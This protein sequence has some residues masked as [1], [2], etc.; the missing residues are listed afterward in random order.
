MQQTVQMN[1]LSAV[2]GTNTHVQGATTVQVSSYTNYNLA[3]VM[4]QAVVD[5]VN[6]SGKVTVVGKG[7][8]TVVLQG[9][10]DE[11]ATIVQSSCTVVQVVAHTSNA[12]VLKQTSIAIDIQITTY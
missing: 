8:A 1:V 6:R 10:A 9:I 3:V 4:E 5:E 12:I 2:L 11:D 7:S